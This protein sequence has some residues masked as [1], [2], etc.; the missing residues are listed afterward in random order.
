[1]DELLVERVLRLVEAIPAGFVVSYGDVAAALGTG[2]R[3]VGRVMARWGSDVP[4]WRVTNAAGELSG[5][6]LAEAR[7]HWQAEGIEL[8]GTGRGCR[9]GRCRWQP[10]EL[11]AAARRVDTELA[12]ARISS[13]AAPPEC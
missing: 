11:A 9:I 2:P 5:G 12:G 1:M 8:G 6:L 4:W 13:P 10:D 3:Q 7:E